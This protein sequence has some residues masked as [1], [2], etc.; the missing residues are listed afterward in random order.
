MD[1]RHLMPT[2][3]SYFCIFLGLGWIMTVP[4][5]VASLPVIWMYSKF[6]FVIL[7]VPILLSALYPTAREFQPHWAHNVGTWMLRNASTYFSFLIEFEDLESL[8]AAASRGPAIFIMEPHG[9]FPITLFWGGLSEVT[10][11]I[12]KLELVCC[13][14]STMFTI[15]LMKHFLTWCGATNI[16]KNNIKVYLDRGVSVN[17]CAGGVQEIQY[18]GEDKELVLFLKSRLGVTKLALTNGVP[19]VPSLCFG[20]KNTYSCWIPTSPWLLSLARKIGFFPMLFTGLGYVPFG[21]PKP[22]P[23]STVIGKPI[24]MP[25]IPNPTHEQIDK[26]HTVFLEAYTKLYNDNKSKYDMDN[27]SLRIV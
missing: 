19:L 24:F 14:S 25:K 22:C 18:W 5:I 13:L 2:F 16:D 10:K 7:C 12:P 11:H 6:T 8:K 17:I 3:A 4:L 20:L 15:P 26:Y 23:L 27:V 9:V 1:N 21:Q